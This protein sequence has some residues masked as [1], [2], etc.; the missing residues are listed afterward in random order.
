MPSNAAVAAGA[1]LGAAFCLYLASP[2]LPAI[3]GAIVLAIVFEPLVERLEQAT[4]RRWLAAL[5]GVARADSVDYGGN[6]SL[7]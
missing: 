6:R 4:Q 7:S 5:I 3:L 1:L 2:F